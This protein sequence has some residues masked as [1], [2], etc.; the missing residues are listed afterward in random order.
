MVSEGEENVGDEASAESI[1]ERLKEVDSP[2]SVQKP[3]EGKSR[4]EEME[5]YLEDLLL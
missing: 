5:E 4:D 3:V 2:W 1:E